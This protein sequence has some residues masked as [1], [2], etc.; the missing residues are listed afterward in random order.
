M[1]N[2]GFTLVELLAV[3]VILA[4][5][6]LIA[7]PMVLGVIEKS[8]KSAAI[9]SA[10]GI[11]DAAEKNMIESMLSG[12]S[13]TRYDL[14][15]DNSLSYKG[16]KPESGI[17]LIDDKGKMS[18]KAKINGYCVLKTYNGTTPTIVDDSICEGNYKETILNGTDPVLKDK[19]IPVTIKDNGEVTYADIT[20][21]WY[22]YE[23]KVWAN[24][25]ILV[26][27][28]SKIYSVGDVILESDIEAYFVWIPKYSYKL[29]DLGNYDSITNIDESKVHSID[30]V[31]G[32]N[33]TSDTKEG[34]C[35]TPLTSG[36]SGNCEVGDYMTHPAFITLGVNGLW[37]GKFETGYSGATS[38]LEAKVNSDDEKMI[39]VK[40]NVYSWRGINVSNAY[41]ASLD[42]NTNLESHMMKNTEWGAV[43]YLHHSKYGSSTELMFNNNSDY[44]TGY[45]SVKSPTCGN[46][47]ENEEC[48]KYGTTSDITQ[49]YNTKVGY[50]ASTTG[51]ISGV[52]D[53]A[54]GTWEYMASYME[55]Q[56]GSSGLI[57]TTIDANTK[58]FDIYSSSSSITSYNQRILGDATGDNGP[59]SLIEIIPSKIYYSNSWYDDFSIFIESSNPWFIRGGHYKDGIMSGIFDFNR[60]TGSTNMAIG[61]RLVLAP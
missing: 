54:G 36:E 2:K 27:S 56:L 47:G 52:Y 9:E 7:T 43:A 46:P 17:L 24:A 19:L 5:I 32:T 10:N 14:S 13:K 22:D 41:N 12:E 21:E 18:I 25:V 26:D 42:Y 33:N 50:K 3:I 58:Y 38:A 49:V 15:N 51:N 1:R 16:E 48:N 61:F 44:L 45:A 6:S 28:P 59:F 57:Q 60:Q 4:V 35:T 30:I 20:T 8:K 23:N 40:P 39:I 34:E 29:W 11:L 31:F 53:M 55:G 37:V